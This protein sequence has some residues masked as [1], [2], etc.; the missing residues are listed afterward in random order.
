MTLIQRISPEAIH[1]SLWTG[2]QLARGA[3]RGVSTGHS[4]LDA[5][6]PGGR[7]P[8][9]VLADVLLRQPGIGE[10]RL[11]VPLLSKLGARPVA[12]VAPP[13][14]LQAVALAHWGLAPSNVMILRPAKTADALWATE[15]TL[16]SGTCG[17]VFLWQSYVRPE[18]LRRLHLA[19]QSG[20]EALFFLFRPL[21]AARETSPAPLRVS[22]APARGGIL[23][24]FVKRRGP[25]RDEPLFV[26]LTPSPVL[27]SRHGSLDR[28]VPAAPRPRVVSADLVDAQP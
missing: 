22:L 27:L 8:Q 15:Q 2:A 12:L 16:R 20:G 10:L 28:R 3:E 25:Q 9:G 26:P 21:A 7:W 4:D 24:S 17:A 11:F 1:A 23:V 14:A 13:H 19:A 18:S 6:L 5:E